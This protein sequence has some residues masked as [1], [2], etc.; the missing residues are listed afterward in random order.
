MKKGSLLELLERGLKLVWPQIKAQKMSVEKEWP[1]D[2]PV[3]LMDEKLLLQAYVN[4][5][6]NALDS[7]TQARRLKVTTSCQE[8][9]VPLQVCIAVE[10]TGKGISKEQLSK[11]G[12]PFFSTK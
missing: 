11:L 1:Q 9:R 3:I 6:V 2:L 7:M 10:D 4:L 8:T 12:Q 5:L